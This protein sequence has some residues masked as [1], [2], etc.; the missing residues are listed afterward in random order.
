MSVTD[1]NVLELKQRE[2]ATRLEFPEMEKAFARV[3]E[4]LV[5]KTFSTR[6]NDTTERERLFLA[7]Q[8]LDAVK[9]AMVEMMGVGSDDIEKYIK[10][11]AQAK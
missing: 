9:S 5:D 7:V 10:Q 3:R 8:T 11:I 6:I 1:L 4:A 2:R